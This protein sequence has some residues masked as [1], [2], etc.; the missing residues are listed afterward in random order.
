MAKEKTITSRVIKL[1]SWGLS[2]P[3]LV[4][5]KAYEDGQKLS[6]QSTVLAD[7]TNAAHKAQILELVAEAKI[8]CGLKQWEYPKPGEEH[9]SEI[10]LC[11]GRADVHP[12]K[13]KYDGYAGMFYLAMSNSDPP[14]ICGRNLESLDPKR[15]PFP[16]AGCYVNTNTTLWVQDNKWGKAIRANLRIVQFVS[17]GAA[18]GK[19]R[20]N[21]E[22]EFEPLG[23][24]P[25]AKARLNAAAGASEM[26]E[27]ISF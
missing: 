2:F 13:K 19:G 18:F 5:P 10:K 21:A 14:T 1:K 4:V 6:Y 15:K 27:D 16:Y 12:K 24:D 20:A 9:M 8:L 25:S 23:D 26:E 22:E 11:F 7:P 3:E 17:D